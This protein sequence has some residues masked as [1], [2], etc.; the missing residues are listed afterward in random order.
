MPLKGELGHV[1]LVP[2]ARVFD[3]SQHRVNS[4]TRLNESL[5]PCRVDHAKTGSSKNGQIRCVGMNFDTP[6][7]PLRPNDD[8]PER[9]QPVDMLIDR[10]IFPRLPPESHDRGEAPG[11][12]CSNSCAPGLGAHQ[13]LLT[14]DQ[15]STLRRIKAP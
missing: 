4:R 8:D 10:G 11:E 13:L 12:F 6:T 7:S 1:D 5:R 2:V 15:D 9:P 3:L 14:I